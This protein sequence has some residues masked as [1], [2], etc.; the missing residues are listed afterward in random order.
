MILRHRLVLAP[1][2]VAALLLAGC[3]GSDDTEA[4]TATEPATSSTVSPTTTESAPATDTAPTTE[5]PTTTTEP[6]APVK[7]LVVGDSV[8]YTLGEYAPTDLPTVVS[9]ESR[10]L[11][12]CGLIPSGERPPEA[13]ALGV[14]PLYDDCGPQIEASDEAGLATDPDVVLLVTGAWERS[15][16]ERDGRVVGPDDAAWTEEIRDLLI[17][18]V[19][20]L[21]TDGGGVPVA[22]W[23]DP[24]GAEADDRIRQDWYRSEVVVPAAEATADLGTTV[25]DPAE[26]V[27]ADGEAAD[28]ESVGN[29]RPDDTQHWSPEGAAWLWQTYLGAALASAAA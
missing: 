10:A 7:V 4:S 15:D 16:H 6:P 28:V 5:A 22:L 23:A 26:V 24:C 25:I 9:V 21:N 20:S 2:V 12:G 3:G 29:P 8:G 14:P 17:A 13:V 1:C 11:P 18:R 19:R 27:C